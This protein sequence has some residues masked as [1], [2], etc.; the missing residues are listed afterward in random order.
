MLHPPPCCRSKGR[1]M[2]F[3]LDMVYK[4]IKN[5]QRHKIEANDQRHEQQECVK[6]V[7]VLVNDR[8]NWKARIK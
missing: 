7:Q 3:I 8:L 4:F 2:C 6:Y 5:E 1:V